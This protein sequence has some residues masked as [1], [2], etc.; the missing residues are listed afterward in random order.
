[1]KGPHGPPTIPAMFLALP[2][3]SWGGGAG[4]PAAEAQGCVCIPV[5]SGFTA[6][7]IYKLFPTL[8]LLKESFLLLETR[9]DKFYYKNILPKK[10]SFTLE[11]LEWLFSPI[12]EV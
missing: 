3:V 12:T 7:A 9:K 5:S 1:M 6:N 10:A 11:K 2:H 8:H 4:R